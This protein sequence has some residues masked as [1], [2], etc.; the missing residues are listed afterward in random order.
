[1]PE[2]REWYFLD[3]DNNK[4]SPDGLHCCRC[5]RKVKDQQAVVSFRSVEMHPEHPWVRN[6]A[7]TGRHL[8]GA[9]CWNKITKD[10]P[11]KL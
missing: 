1:M 8:I 9:D 6:A 5:K 7:L 11:V 2:N 10:G 4:E 3:P